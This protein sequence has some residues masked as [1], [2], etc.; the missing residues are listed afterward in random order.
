MTDTLTIEPRFNGPP[1]SGNGGYSFG[2]LAQFV[3]A[4]AAEVTLRLPPPIGRPL[5]VERCDD[6]GARLVD[7]DAL[8][9]EARPADVPA[10]VP[11]PVEPTEA[12]D[13]AE[14]SLF[15]DVDT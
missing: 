5:E 7:G 2:R 14:D 4:Q 11:P 13:A 15:L 10:E 9:A 1:D 6:G 3:D 8:I 12:A